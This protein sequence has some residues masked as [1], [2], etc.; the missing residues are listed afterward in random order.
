MEIIIEILLLFVKISGITRTE[1]TVEW[2]N[3]N[4]TEA[5]L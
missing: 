5:D 4:I 1:G 3:K 2:T